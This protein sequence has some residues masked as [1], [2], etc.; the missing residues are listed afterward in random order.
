MFF[1]ISYLLT[2]LINPGTL[3]KKYYINNFILSE[4]DDISK[5]QKCKICNIIF[6]KKLKVVHCKIC[7]ICIIGQDHHCP[8]TGKCIGKYNIIQFNCFLAGILLFMLTTFMTFLLF[9]IHLE[10]EE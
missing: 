6:P 1:L 8:W 4:N 9:L 7:N 3:D 2:C 10:E 5:Y